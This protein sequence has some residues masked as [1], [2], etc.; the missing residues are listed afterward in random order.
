MCYF[1]C[2]LIQ[3]YILLLVFWNNFTRTQDPVRAMR[4]HGLDKF[5]WTFYTTLPPAQ[6]HVSAQPRTL[7]P[8]PT[9]AASSASH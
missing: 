6:D 4:A 8:C 9:Y 3:Y 5:L 7:G 1:Q 2:H